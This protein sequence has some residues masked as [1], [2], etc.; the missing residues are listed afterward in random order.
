MPWLLLS[1]ADTAPAPSST[2]FP[3]T[4]RLR[5][6]K[7]LGEDQTRRVA[8]TVQRD[9]PL[10]VCST[11]KAKGKE[12][13]GTIALPLHKTSFILTHHVFFSIFFSPPVLLRNGGIQEI[14]EHLASS[15]GCLTTQPYCSHCRTPQQSR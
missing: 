3:F 10:G 4:S 9:I 13:D 6:G 5:V 2:T 8:Q 12:E 15:Q 11:A 7:I 1:S 14:A